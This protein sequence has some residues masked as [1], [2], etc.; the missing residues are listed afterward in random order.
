[1]TS[2]DYEKKCKEILSPH[3]FKS[4]TFSSL[5]D[6][7]KYIIEECEDGYDWEFSEYSNEI[8]CRFLIQ[9]LMC[10][11]ELKE[12]SFHSELVEKT[13][14]LDCRFKKL[15]QDNVSIDGDYWWQKGVLIQAGDEYCDYMKDAYNIE[16]NR[17]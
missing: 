7:W 11:L 2:S 5:I 8:K 3:G 1:M 16:V 15:F 13:I 17:L 10:S 4:E 12:F 9:L 6:K 14:Q